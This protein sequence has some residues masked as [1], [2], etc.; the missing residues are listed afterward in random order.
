MEPFEVTAC[1]T[2]VV[3]TVESRPAPRKPKSS[4]EKAKIF[5]RLI[6]IFGWSVAVVGVG[7]FTY[8]EAYPKVGQKPHQVGSLTLSQFGFWL[9]VSGVGLVVVSVISSQ[10]VSCLLKSKQEEYSRNAVHASLGTAHQEEGAVSEDEV[11]PLIGSSR[12]NYG[13]LTANNASPFSSRIRSAAVITSA[14]SPFP[15]HSLITS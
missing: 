7:I 1:L 2:F 15:N 6:L 11:E 14:S 3:M 10:S 8:S 5:L 9:I 13:S 4:L 12:V